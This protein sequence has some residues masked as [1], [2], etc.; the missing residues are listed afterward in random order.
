[1]HLTYHLTSSI[2]ILEI[3]DFNKLKDSMSN[4]GDNQD[5]ASNDLGLGGS[6]KV[7]IVANDL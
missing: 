5:P 2:F 7:T 4:M 3:Y 1:M 6:I